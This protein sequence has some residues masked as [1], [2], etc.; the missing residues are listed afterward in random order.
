M[1]PADVSSITEQ[2]LELIDGTVPGLVRGFYLT[3][4]IPLDDYVPGSS[5]IDGVVVVSEPVTDPEVVR[6]VHERLPGRPYFDVTYLT[7]SALASPPD[8]GTCD[9]VAGGSGSRRRDHSL[10]RPRHSAPART[11]CYRQHCL[12]DGGWSA[13]LGVVPVVLRALPACA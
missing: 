3:G 5:D 12:Q 10:V 7:A 2:Y 13:R 6:A 8:R 9:G 1:I 4:S 11:A